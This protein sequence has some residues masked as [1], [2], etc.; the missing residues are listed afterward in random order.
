M[1]RILNRRTR[2]ALAVAVAL[3]TGAA[4][5]PGFPGGAWAGSI[6]RIGT[7]GAPEL[8]ISVGPR[9]NALGG[10]AV[11]DVKG[12]EALY[13]NPAGLAVL[14]GTEAFF[15]HLTHI[16]ETNVNYFSIATR[17]GNFGNLGLSAKVFDVG[18]VIVTTEQAPDGTGEILSP[19][20]ATIGASYARQFT[21]RVRFGAT[22]QFVNEAVLEARARGVAFDFG[23]QYDTNEHGLVFGFVMKNFGPSLQFS[24]AAFETNTPPPGSEPGSA[25][26]TLTFET[27]ENELP[28][29]F[30]L[31][32]A[33]NAFER[34]DH[35][36]Q[37]F[38]AFT[39]NNF[40]PDDYR[41]GAEYRWRDY[42]A[43]RAGYNSFTSDNDV[44]SY[45]GLSFGAGISA[46]LAGA[47]LQFDYAHRMVEDFWN[48]T[49]EFG[50][51]VVF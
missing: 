29:Y 10:N 6:E 5:L 34:E 41:L 19:T 18:D 31:G 49:N 38:G 32:A 45:D 13:W 28:S 15:T 21:D 16:G 47:H 26:R 25:N 17:A 23:F 14:N 7:N 46:P 12:S 11:G 43:L 33:Y 8:L 40:T 37:V 3:G 36:V 27:T 24:G 48:D 4:A 39:S 44:N 42:L 22:V 1:N 9:S 20:F 30:Q 50:L 35:R 2:L 51:R